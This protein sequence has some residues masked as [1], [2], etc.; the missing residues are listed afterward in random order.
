MMIQ[1]RK[2]TLVPEQ[3]LDSSYLKDLMSGKQLNS[4]AIQKFTKAQK[5]DPFC[6]GVHQGPGVKIPSI[7]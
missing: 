3:Y 5:I 4:E 2:N 6:S 7:K 1:R